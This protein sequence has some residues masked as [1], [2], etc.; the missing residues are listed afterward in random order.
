VLAALHPVPEVEPINLEQ[1]EQILCSVPLPQLVEVAVVEQM[2][3]MVMVVVVQA[4]LAAGEA[5]VFLIL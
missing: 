2:G 5:G 3:R 4:V 1:M